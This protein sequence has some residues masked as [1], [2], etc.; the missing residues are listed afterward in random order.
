MHTIDKY[1]KRRCITKYYHFCKDFRRG[2]GIRPLCS[3]SSLRRGFRG[4]GVAL[5]YCSRD[6]CAYF[7]VLDLS[8]YES[9]VGESDTVTNSDQTL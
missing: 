8:L 5:A 7:K 1:V 4:G 2:T 3:F 9:R 6:F